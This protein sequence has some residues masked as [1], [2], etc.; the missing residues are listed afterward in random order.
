MHPR[1]LQVHPST[2]RRLLRLRK[3]AE[4]ENQYRVAKRIH[5]VLLNSDGQTSGRIADILKSPRSKVSE[6]LLNYEDHGFDGLLE[7][8]RSGRPGRLSQEQRI[9]LDDIIESGPV[10][11]GLDCGIWTSPMIARV[12]EEEFDISY[13]PGHVRKLLDQMGFSVQRPKRLLARADPDK[14][15]RWKRWTY[16]NIKKKPKEKAELS[17]SQTRRASGRTRHSMRP[18]RASVANHSSR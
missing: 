9:A 12:I 5:A 15:R 4:S 1:F 11:Y 7:G 18:G 3:E 16:P 17:S 8:H 10:A 13:H 6:W 14:Q 2:Y